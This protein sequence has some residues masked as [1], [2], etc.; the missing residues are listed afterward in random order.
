MVGGGS[1]PHMTAHVADVLAHRCQRVNH[2]HGGAQR[3][4][5]DSSAV[6]DGA[7]THVE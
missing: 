2:C 3:G 1:H 5:N 6:N 4:H 7:V